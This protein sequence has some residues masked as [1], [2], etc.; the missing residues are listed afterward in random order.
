MREEEFLFA[1]D[2]GAKTKE[3]YEV[4]KDGSF[5]GR[6]AGGFERRV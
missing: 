6:V 4:K 3:E 1:G 2:L 5:V